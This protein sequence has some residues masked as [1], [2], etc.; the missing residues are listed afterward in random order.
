MSRAAL[1]AE[2]KALLRA[3]TLYEARKSVLAFTR[4]TFPE[5]RENWHHRLICQKL[6]DLVSGR[7]ANLMV[8]APPRHT[9]SELVSRRLPA[10]AL[11]VNPDEQIISCSYSDDLASRMNRDVQRIIEC[12]QYA[13]VFPNTRLNSKNIRTT[14][15]G[16]WLK[17]SDIFEV[18]GRRGVYRSAGIGGGITGMGFTLGI[19]DD[20]I[21]NQEE[22][23]SPTIRQ[24]HWEWYTTTFATRMQKCARKLVT[25]TRWNEDDLPGRLLDLASKDGTKWEVVELPAVCEE[26]ICAGDPRQV[27]ELLW[28]Q[29]FDAAFMKEQKTNLGPLFESMYQQRPRAKKGNMVKEEW[30]A[31]RWE[32]LPHELRK[33]QSWDFSFKKTD[34][35]SYVAGFVIGVSGADIYLIERHKEREDFPA[36]LSAFRGMCGAHPECLA[37]L[38][39]EKANGP[40]II[41]S[42]KNEIPGVIPIP[43]DGESKESRLSACLPRFQAGNVHLPKNAPWTEDCARE[44]TTFPRAANDDQVDAISQFITWYDGRA[45]VPVFSNLAKLFGLEVNPPPAWITA[46]EEIQK[47]H[48][49]GMLHVGVAWANEFERESVAVALNQ[50]GSMVAYSTRPAC[51]V[52]ETL[53]WVCSFCETTALRSAVPGPEINLAYCLRQPGETLTDPLK[54]S[55]LPWRL[56][57]YRYDERRKDRTIG[58]LEYACDACA[59]KKNEAALFLMPWRALY[60]QVSEF[61]KVRCDD[62]TF[63]YAMAEGFQGNALRALLLANL[64]YSEIKDGTTGVVLLDPT[65]GEVKRVDAGGSTT[66]GPPSGS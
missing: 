38:I 30:L 62:N 27:G 44:L 60:E 16:S 49:S 4:Y 56:Y 31:D 12:P 59:E 43:C 2:F 39:E 50:S 52:I 55:P 54:N 35:G 65:T 34:D 3:Q 48:A 57:P 9:K 29:E 11:G 22:A 63:K 66:P 14:A 6:D 33:Y 18:V 61:R 32:I 21:K 23:A 53:R 24:K 40:A 37:K 17:N 45:G 26:P 36:M 42:V 46:S 10:F 47:G 15:A 19:I 5:F 25:V 58:L 28:P 41:S 13:E 51:S 64:L 8:F 20:P 7:I 1:E